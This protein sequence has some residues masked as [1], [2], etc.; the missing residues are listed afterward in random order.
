MATTTS[1]SINVK[2]FLG[3][4]P[5]RRGSEASLPFRVRIFHLV[6]MDRPRLRVS[7]SLYAV[8]G[9]RTCRLFEIDEV[10][11]RWPATRRRE[12][13]RWAVL[14]VAWTNRYH[15]ARFDGTVF[16]KG[17][18]MSHLVSCRPYSYGKH[19]D[20]AWSHL[21]TLGIQHVEI[22]IPSAEE[23]DAT[24]GLLES[25]G[26]SVG[27]F[28]GTCD[29]AAGDAAAS[30]ATQCNVCKQFGVT[31]LFV[32]VKAGETD[33]QVVWDRLRAAGDE[34]AKRDVIIML[35][36]HPDLVT[37]GD[38]GAQTMAAVDHANV[39]INFDTANVYYYNEGV[40]AV[41]E[42][43]KVL[44]CVEGIHLKDTDGGYQKHYFPAL[45]T[46]VVDF[47]A[48]VKLLADRGFTGPFTMELEG[49]AGVEMTPEE[50][51]QYVADSAAYLRKIGLLT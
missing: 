50:Q 5:A 41:G 39:R 43:R 49:M 25:N 42:I 13:G 51:K 19:I 27:S 4:A 29:I 24:R 21:P 3:L 32:S 45:G 34:A 14:V 46:G 30:M 17:L 48:V 10:Q 33:R 20:L 16:W 35:E 1:N 23:M 12:G 11:R 36:T 18:A 31:R 6:S 7:S 44:D 47:P 37:N 8:T 9:S 26:L 28:Q 22:P 2:P 40:D 15:S 38:V